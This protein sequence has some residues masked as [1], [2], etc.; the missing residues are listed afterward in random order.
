MKDEY[1][2][3]ECSSSV[4]STISA[5]PLPTFTPTVHDRLP[6]TPTTL[7]PFSF[8]NNLALPSYDTKCETQLVC[9]EQHDALSEVSADT[10]TPSVSWASGTPA[11]DDTSIEDE[12]S[13][14]VD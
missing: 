12:P 7:S 9:Q 8:D 10:S 5:A 6:Y 13:R 3:R 11:A 14:H 1:P 4:A 2:T